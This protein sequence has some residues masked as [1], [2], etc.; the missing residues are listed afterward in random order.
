M[1]ERLTEGA[2]PAADRDVSSDDRSIAV[3]YLAYGPP[4]LVHATAFS[5]LT[6]LHAARSLRRPWTLSVYTDQ[7]EIFR[8]Y[9][10]DAELIPLTALT[11]EGEGDYLH[12]S[13]IQAINHAARTHEGDV[14]YLDGDTYFRRSPADLFARLS[15]VRTIMHKYEWMLA[16]PGV[17]DGTNAFASSLGKLVAEGDFRSP[18]LQAARTRQDLA[19]W[20]AGAIGIAAENKHLIPDVISVADELYEAYGYHIVEQL[21]WALVFSQAGELVP[22]DEF[23]YHYW[24]GQEELVHRTVR[25]LR[26]SARRSRD[27]L[28]ATA[29]ELK[30]TVTPDWKP[31]LTVRARVALR[32]TRKLYRRL[33][34]A[35][36]SAVP[37][38]DRR[39]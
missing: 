14:F 16:P 32:S 18:V 34:T 8:R 31:P 10:V 11:S 37:T 35:A 21:A 15:P 33:R 20:N 3:L 22:A 7:P 5:A 26:G 36:P 6:F 24:D 39:S 29:F 9:G 38:P 23:I 30:P 27:E 13:K 25:F 2:G 1:A 12:R 19:M 28:R 4:R 17:D